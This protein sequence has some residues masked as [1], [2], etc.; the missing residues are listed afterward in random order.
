ML[1][2]K[3]IRENPGLVEEAVKKRGEEIDLNNFLKL[4]E[5]RKS[6]YTK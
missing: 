5:R 4:D 2:I 6:C 3:I 1:D